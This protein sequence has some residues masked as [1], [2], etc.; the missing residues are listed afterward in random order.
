MASFKLNIVCLMYEFEGSGDHVDPAP[1]EKPIKGAEIA[2]QGTNWRAA[3]NEDGCRQ[4]A[5]ICVG[6]Y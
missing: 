1:G 2:V 6:S 5:D 3:S 4:I